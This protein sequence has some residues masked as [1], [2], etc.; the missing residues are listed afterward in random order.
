MPELEEMC[1][2]K[3]AVKVLVG[4]ERWGKELKDLVRRLDS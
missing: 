1:G 4:D 2:V 3:C